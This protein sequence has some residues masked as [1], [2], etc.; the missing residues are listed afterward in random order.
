MANQIVWEP[1]GVLIILSGTVTAYEVA[2]INDTLYGDARFDHI[3]YQIADYSL[4][5]QNLLTAP[6]G[7]VIGMMDRS[8]SRWNTHMLDVLITKDPAFKPVI[9]TYAKMLK[10]TQ[11]KFRVFETLEEGYAWIGSEL[12]R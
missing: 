11:W 6:D 4:V 7:K 8:S 10:D 5:T 2:R 3:K 9:D 1:K 12:G